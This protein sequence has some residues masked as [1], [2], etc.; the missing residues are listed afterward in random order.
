[1]K[2]DVQ[3]IKH[4]MYMKKVTLSL[5]S[6]LF[7]LSVA[8][9][10]STL[11]ST[12][13]LPVAGD[14]YVGHYSDTTGFVLDTAR[15]AANWNY[16]TL[17]NVETDTLSF[18]ACAT[19]PYCDSFT[20]SNLV[21]KGY[22]IYTYLKATPT[23]LEI[24]GNSESD[25]ILR[26]PNSKILFQFPFTYN[27]SFVDS[28][29]LTNLDFTAKYLDSV[30]VVGY[31]TLQT[32]TG[33][34]NNTLMVR[35]IEKT[36]FITGSMS[37]PGGVTVNYAWYKQGFH[38]PLMTAIFEQLP[39]GDTK[40]NSVEY[41]TG[42]SYTTAVN[43]IK[44]TVDNVNV[45]PNPANGTAHIAFT[46]DDANT[47]VNVIDINGRTVAN[48]DNEVKM[49]KNNLTLSTENLADGIYIVSIVAGKEAKTIRLVVSK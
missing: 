14:V 21:S 33:T 35:T 10:Q 11:T 4:P 17:T 19:S 45:Y 7:G 6:V 12:H 41:F 34:H 1:M 13:L 8:N 3:I 38:S 25:T 30:K 39:S 36:T 18:Y 44:N 42:P 29:N 2:T 49:G 32:P 28:S 24:L 16:S 22:G 5:L 23:S 40:I 37:F 15:I 9:A 47:A 27:S 31:G 48:F 20:G 26:M 43:D 46:T